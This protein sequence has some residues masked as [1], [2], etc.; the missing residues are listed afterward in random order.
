MRIS[1]PSEQSGTPVASITVYIREGMLPRGAATSATRTEYGDEHLARLRV[2][3][4]LSDVRA[5]PL[6]RVKEILALIG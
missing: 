5:L 3:L 1:E 2:I 6:A 4:A